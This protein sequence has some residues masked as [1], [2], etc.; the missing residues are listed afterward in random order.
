MGIGS[1]SSERYGGALAVRRGTAV[2]H[3]STFSDNKANECGAIYAVGGVLDIVF[4]PSGTV[5][6][7]N[8][9]RTGIEK[10]RVFGRMHFCELTTALCT[11]V[12]TCRM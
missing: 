3:S 4:P 7:S 9:F 2:I 10:H 5:L 8:R 11:R 6:F 1:S 12:Y